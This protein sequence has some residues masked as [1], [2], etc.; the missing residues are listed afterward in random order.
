MDKRKNKPRLKGSIEVKKMPMT[1][2]T[3][4]GAH[5][6]ERKLTRSKENPN[7]PKQP[8]KRR[9]SQS[10][11]IPQEQSIRL[12]IEMLELVIDSVADGAT[13]LS[14]SLV[15]KAWLVRCRYYLFSRVSTPAG[16]CVK[17]LQIIDPVKVKAG[18]KPKRTST[19]TNLPPASTFVQSLVI[20]PSAESL[21]APCLSVNPR[22]NP[23]LAAS[24]LVESVPNL[25]ELQLSGVTEW[26]LAHI[27]DPLSTTGKLQDLALLDMR[28]RAWMDVSTPL[29]R[30]AQN[31]VSLRMSGLRFRQLPSV[32]GDNDNESVGIKD[33]S[34]TPF[35]A[36][37]ICFPRLRRLA[38]EQEREDSPFAEQLLDSLFK[39]PSGVPENLEDLELPLRIASK[40]KTFIEGIGLS[41][42]TLTIHCAG[43]KIGQQGTK[44]G[45]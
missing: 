38:I 13:L 32:T 28:C 12:P 9:A 34:F 42:R 19:I 15:C 21:L 3:C 41:L 6:T 2:S 44:S 10:K 24:L 40:S 25:R 18:S 8:A 11:Q 37:D 16:A 23:S 26:A 30:C 5:S 20:T 29:V 36:H 4:D 45:M 1:A 43:L 35:L 17:L 22:N 27:L 33:S 39:S 31:L 7:P 14:C